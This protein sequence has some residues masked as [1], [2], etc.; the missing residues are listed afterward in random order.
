M[1]E[2]IRIE[3]GIVKAVRIFLYLLVLGGCNIA[4]AAF[5]RPLADPVAAGMGRAGLIIERSGGFLANPALG[6]KQ[7][8]AIWWDRPYGLT[9]LGSERVIA[10]LSVKDS[11]FGVSYG[12]TGDKAYSE[13]QVSAAGSYAFAPDVRVGLSASWYGLAVDG[14]PSGSAGVLNLGIVGQVAKDLK[15][16]AV[17]NNLSQAK[18]SNYEDELPTSIAAG[19]LF[20]A[21]DR[22][23]LALEFEQQ[24]GWPTEVRA[25]INSRVLKPL[26]L[27]GG[28]RFNP[29][30]YTAGFSLRHRALQVHYALLWHRD[31]GASHAIGL[32]VFLR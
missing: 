3:E 11:D 4:D 17:W 19:L 31:L 25:G 13:K 32:D 23:E 8:I 5:E 26:T 30:E 1:L 24:P 6:F 29:A 14:L 22:T 2:S 10:A 15:A 27:R 7:N 18:L 9:E 16:S 12:Q 28:A 20:E 21:D